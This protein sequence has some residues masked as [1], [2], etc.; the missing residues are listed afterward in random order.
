MPKTLFDKVVP[1]YRSAVVPD[2]HWAS[3][4]HPYFIPNQPPPPCG[5]GMPPV[6][7]PPGPRPPVGP[8][9]MD[10]ATAPCGFVENKPTSP[11]FSP[12]GMG[13]P[14]SAEAMPKP[15]AVKVKGN[16][17]KPKMAKV[18]VG[19][20]MDRAPTPC[21]IHD[22]SAN[23][24]VVSPLG[25]A[26]MGSPE[27]MPVRPAEADARNPLDHSGIRQAPHPYIYWLA[28][29]EVNVEAGD[30]VDVTLMVDGRTGNK[31]YTVS[32]HTPEEDKKRIEALERK[33]E[34]EL[35]EVRRIKANMLTVSED[36]TEGG[37]G[38]VFSEGLDDDVP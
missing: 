22:G 11:I 17:K 34:A 30:N 19:P 2:N 9:V 28:K 24:P 3:V 32:S 38:I 10:R 13:G 18:P 12:V 21:H 15:Q 23:S 29:R 16:G 6:P 4:C 36:E 26:V 27:A 37:N 35:E 14:A 5:C 7:P 31:T 20:I 8:A 1:E 33:L 25:Q